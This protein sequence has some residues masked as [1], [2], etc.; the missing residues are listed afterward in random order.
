MTNEGFWARFNIL[1]GD[2]LLK[3]VAYE[4]GYT[5]RQIV[6]LS[7]KNRLPNI[8]FLIRCSNFFNVSLDFLVFGIEEKSVS[9][10][11]KCLLSKSEES[12]RLFKLI[13]ELDDAE[14]S[15]VREACADLCNSVKKGSSKL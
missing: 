14:L 15:L 1:K 8:K 11:T 12:L 3:E 4:L 7:S 9:E 10:K 6:N 2:M 5:S 13:S